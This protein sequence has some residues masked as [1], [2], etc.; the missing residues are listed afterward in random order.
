ETTAAIVNAGAFASVRIAYRRSC[1][2]VSMISSLRFA[3]QR[4][5][6][7]RPASRFARGVNLASMCGDEAPRDRQTQSGAPRCG[8]FVE[9]VEHS[10]DLLLRHAV[11]RV[12]HVDRRSA[13]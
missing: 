10:S 5:R 13:G 6:D 7:R 2:V 3:R 11:T 12:A 8:S 9:A 4:E 1:H